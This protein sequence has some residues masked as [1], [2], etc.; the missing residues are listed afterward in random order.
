MHSDREI[1]DTSRSTL[2]VSRAARQP[3]SCEPCRKRKIKCSRTTPPCDTCK[4]RGLADT[5]SYV[6]NPSLSQRGSSITLPPSASVV[7]P[8]ETLHARITNLEQL[9]QQNTQ[10]PAFASIS[11]ASTDPTISSYVEASPSTR[12]SGHG[13]SR[14]TLRIGTLTTSKFGYVK[15]EPRSS[16][17]TSILANTGILPIAP[18]LNDPYDPAEDSG[19]FPIT[20]ASSPSTGELL[21]ILPP[22]QHC[23]Q[24]KDLYFQ[25]FSP[26][27]LI[28]SAKSEDDQITYFIFLPAFSYSS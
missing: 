3:V 20:S 12:I 15:Y 5:C 13:V 19:G 4:R 6:S 14:S 9:L 7:Y 18:S 27:C 23:A 26:V 1:S 11:P 2:R 28:S 24:L 16:Q 8:N 10:Q 22:T 21:A 17:W 25:V